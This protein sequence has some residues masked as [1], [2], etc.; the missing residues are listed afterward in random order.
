MSLENVLLDINEQETEEMQVA[1][2]V[3]DLESAIEA[4]RRIA[5]F[6]ERQAEIDRIIEKQIAPYLAKIEKIKEWGIQAKVEHE[7][8]QAYYTILLE[9]YMRKEIAEQIEVGKKPKKTWSF[10]YGKVSL[11]K[12]QPEF[13]KDEATLLEYAKLAGF[14]KVKESTDWAELKKSCVVADGKL[15]DMNGEQV[16]GVVVVER[17]EKFTVELNN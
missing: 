4:Q 5:W 16:P 1:F 6:V 12:Q 3:N 7:E 11:K 14:V 8:K 9:Q 10:P 13:Q 15:Y 17:D 2:V